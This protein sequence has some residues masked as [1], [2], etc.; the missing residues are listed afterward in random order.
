MIFTKNQID[1]NS[2]YWTCYGFNGDELTYFESYHGR[3]ARQTTH[4]AYGLRM[5]VTLSSDVLFNSQK[6][7]TKTLTGGNMDTYGGDQTY[8]CWAIAEGSAT[9]NSD[10]ITRTDGHSNTSEEQEFELGYV[11]FIKP[12]IEKI[13]ATKDETAKTETIVFTATD[14]Y[15]SL[16]HI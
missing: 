11:D 2:F 6:T 16:I 4:A 14:K 12:E 9:N 10:T 3:E 15:L 1:N 8:N 7:G 13:S 5:L